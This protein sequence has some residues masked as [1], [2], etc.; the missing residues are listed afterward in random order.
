MGLRERAALAAIAAVA[1]CTAAD[2]ATPPA[3]VGLPLDSLS[4]GG[5]DNRMT[6]LGAVPRGVEGGAA[7]RSICRPPS[8]SSDVTTLHENERE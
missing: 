4:F 7:S 2:G 8:T 6:G 5:G 1:A 3:V